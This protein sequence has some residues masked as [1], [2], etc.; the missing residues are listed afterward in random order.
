M[1]AKKLGG[2]CAALF[3]A[4]F[5][6]LPLAAERAELV[7]DN[8]L[9][10]KT[11]LRSINGVDHLPLKSV[12][13]LFKGHTQW[14]PVAN[15][16]TLQLNN[17]K[18]I[19]NI[20]KK[21]IQIGGDKHQ[22]SEPARMADGTIFVPVD[23]FTGPP[24]TDIAECKVTWDRSLQ[25][26]SATSKAT[27]QLPRVYSGTRRTR[28][29]I[30]S[31]EDM[32]PEVKKKGNVIAIEIPKAKISSEESIALSDRQVKR[33]LYQRARKGAL[34]KLELAQGVTYYAHSAEQ[35]P[36]R[37]VLEIRSPAYFKKPVQDD[38][39]EIDLPE[40]A[41]AAMPPAASPSA[42]SSAT[43]GAASGAV[44]GAP[45][46]AA[47]PVLDTGAPPAPAIPSVGDAAPDISAG[48]A[49][50]SAPSATPAAI[51]PVS[52]RKAPD[53]ARVKTIVV[54]AGHGGKDPGAFGRGG[55]KEKDINL[56]IALELARILKIEGGYKVLLTRSDDT[57]V[58]LIDRSVFANEA[59]A[60]LFISIHCNASIRRTEG[61]FEIYYLAEEASDE[62]AEEA[63]KL[64]NAVISLEGPLTPKKKRLQDLLF[65]MAQTEFINESSLLSHAINR[66]VKKRVA[67][68]SRGVKQANFHVLHGV[69]MPS[70]LVE[71]A[72]VTHQPEEKKLRSRKWRS[73]MVDAILTGVQNYEKELSK[74][75]R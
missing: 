21:S 38:L 30:E 13:E 69:N 37:L 18:I 49:G 68:Q 27:L 39:D 66:S 42:P 3:I 62:H 73:S 9:V 14:Q 67:I 10:K 24:F 70:V 74:L 17:Q 32:S 58:P 48:K 34:I 15:K 35:D 51:L 40:R 59:K 26:L 16:V 47:T 23:F 7:Y 4:V 28:V 6:A 50:A 61:G 1:P 8:D 55:T 65:S 57:F 19:F 25:M 44:S 20:G 72:F 45:P 12:A 63:E 5:S 36:T 41:P 64:E 43:P 60:D 2:L 29:M 33:I 22:L 11:E 46:T 54:D 71:S 31:S 75:E 52:G 53:K 56:L